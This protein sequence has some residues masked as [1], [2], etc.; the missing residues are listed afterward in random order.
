MPQH[1]VVP[2]FQ[3]PYV[4]NRDEQWAPLW[5]DVRRLAE[6][7]LEDRFGNPTHF[8]GAVVVQSQDPIPGSL[9]AA[10][11][12]DGQQRL[13]TVQLLMDAVAAVLEETGSDALADQLDALTHNQSM[14]VP[15]GDTHLKLRH[16]NRDR[17]A[18]DEVMSAE[19][20]VDHARLRHAGSLVA[21]AHEYFTDMVR[22]WLGLAA[23]AGTGPDAR[24]AALVDALTR[25]LQIVSINLAPNENSQEIFETLNAR[26]T[27]LTA[28]DLIKNF[29][30]QRLASE[31][32]DT[33]RA[34]AED[35]PFESK[36][37]EAELSV[38]RY[39][40]TR[41][42]LFFN[43]WLIS[44]VGEEISPKATF[45]RFKAFVERESGQKV[46][47]LLPVIKAQA[48]AYEGWTTAA[49]DPYRQLTRVE[50][51][52]Y[53]MRTSELEL[54]K[55]LVLWLLEPGR[56]V[57]SDVVDEVVGMAE[58]WVVRRQLLR[59]A[60]GDLGRIVADIIRVHRDAAPTD[61]GARV[62]VHLARLSVTSTYWPGDEE[63]R[64]ALGSEQVY[65]RFKRSRLRFLL[66]AIEDRFRANTR[67]PQV[68]RAGYP[69]EHVLPQKWADRWP[70]ATEADEVNR[71]DHVHRLGNLT[72]LTASLNSKVSNGP[73]GAKREALQQHDTLLLNSRLLR[74]AP[75]VW[76]EAGI[77]ERTAQMVDSILA[78]WPVPDGHTG[79]VD[80]PLAK[81]A[82][83]WVELKHLIGAGLLVPGTVLTPRVGK[84]QQHQA[85]VRPNGQL[86]VDGRTFESPS[87]AGAYV[88]GGSTNGWHFWRL[89]DGRSLL[90][91][92]SAYNGTKP[93][94]SVAPFD[95]ALLHAILN[96]I[97][98]GHWTTYGQ[99]ADV[100][101][102]APQPVGNH[103]ASCQQCVNAHRVLATGGVVA[104]RFAWHDPDDTRD[105]ADLL[106]SEGVK[107]VD[108][109]ADPERA[110]GAN[111]LLKLVEPG[112]ALGTD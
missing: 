84:W 94:S 111:E 68:P 78:T 61:L 54:L 92:R 83:D 91:V 18:F 50:M 87:G 88:R 16:T 10:N 56:D 63:I 58:S 7:R 42:S 101:G 48:E 41:S 14:Y 49:E 52:F 35:W 31:G 38:G 45:S 43:Q 55:P 64:R 108:G 34:Y 57:P 99:L 13:T 9:Q 86:D 76:D 85:L 11:V 47:E 6:L 98:E 60:G 62:R 26:G 39:P 105:P 65:R 93:K 67:Q 1:L 24:S 59:L 37:W 112:D 40:V 28:A 15:A 75:D 36:F 74:S 71:A 12:I 70:V 73:W 23:V 90:D 22:E 33:K 30:F 95:W 19:P 96:T 21:L 32:V 51:A 69:I 20:P 44:R 29:V 66:E 102:T 104:A 109:R 46:S 5:H 2:P 81:K 53:R 82:Q 27:P 77:D 89:P 4:W 17:A 80:D 3:R 79:S 97:P 72:L 106:R 103:I 107:V 25:G 110:L 8:L 100:V